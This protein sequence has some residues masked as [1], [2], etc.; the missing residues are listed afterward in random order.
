MSAYR[1]YLSPPYQTGRELEA[2]SQVLNSNWLAPV[3]PALDDFELAL[4]RLTGAKCAVA[5]QSGTAALHLSMKL[6]GIGKGDEVLVSSF[7][8]NATIN[9]ILYT[10]ATPVLID[11]DANTWNMDL[12]LLEEAIRDRMRKGKKPAA[13]LVVHLY[14]N[15]MDMARLM[16]L[17]AEYEI[18]VVEDAAEALGSYWNNRHLGT[19][20][21][22]GVLSFNG[23]K[24]ITTT[25]GGALLTNQE[26]FAT[27][28]LYLATQAR[29]PV[30][31]FEHKEVGYNYRMSNLL[32]AFGVG[33]LTGFERFLEKRISNYAKY[34][35]FFESEW[36]PEAVVFQ[37]VLSKGASNHWLSAF[38]FSQSDL[39]KRMM[40][41][42]EASGIESRYL[43]KPMHLQPVF[44]NL[45][46]YGSGISTQL[47]ERGICLPSGY[48]LTDADFDLIFSEIRS[49]K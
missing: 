5:L 48:A 6:L 27:K 12:D 2:L 33:Q 23:N 26:V 46:F 49:L 21:V 10:G 29:E 24:I 17:S 18:P 37:Q 15:P 13:I 38:V 22:M 1:I 39:N 25:G 4:T 43:W 40:K 36:G 44:Q 30:E 9:S 16:A 41:A 19:F 45:D 34:R 8:H 11:S 35:T 20:G 31:W 42:L 47:F 3:G 28:A 7:T 32:A 14:G